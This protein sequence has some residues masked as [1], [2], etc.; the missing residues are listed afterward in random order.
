M[1]FVCHLLS[2]IISNCSIISFCFSPVVLKVLISPASMKC[3]HV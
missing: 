1:V 3:M 2:A